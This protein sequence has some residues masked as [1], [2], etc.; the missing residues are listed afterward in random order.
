VANSFEK[1]VCEMLTHLHMMVYTWWCWHI[2]KGEEVGEEKEL[3]ALV[4]G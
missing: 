4:T 1:N 2:F 3:K